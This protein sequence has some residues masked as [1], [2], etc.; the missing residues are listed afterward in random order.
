MFTDLRGFTSFG[1]QREPEQVIEVLNRYLT[2][3]SAAIL[4]EGGT[5]VA[6]MGDGIMAV[7]GAPVPADDHADRA[8]RTARRMLSE[9]DAFNAELVA[10]GIGDGFRM[11]IGLNSG[12]VMSGNVG[13][14]RRLEYTALGDTTNTAARLEAMTKDLSCQLVLSESTRMLLHPPP[15]D[16]EAL[17]EH[18]VRGREHPIVL[19]TVRGA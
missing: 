17:G 3:M 13:S 18:P 16:L 1:E 7:F 6:Y 9:L 11:G 5:L 15:D 10:D 2:R 4:D 12:A 19:W 8:L 14:E